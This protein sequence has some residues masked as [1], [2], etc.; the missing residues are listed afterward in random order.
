MY[1]PNKDGNIV[2]REQIGDLMIEA[3]AKG[4]ELRRGDGSAIN[5]SVEEAEVLGMD[6][7][8]CEYLRLYAATHQEGL[9]EAEKTSR[10]IVLA[11]FAKKRNLEGLRQLEADGFDNC[12]TLA[13]NAIYEDAITQGSNLDHK[14]VER[15]VNLGYKGIGERVEVNVCNL[16]KA[17]GENLT[18]CKLA[19]DEI[20]TD[21]ATI[22]SAILY[23]RSGDLVIEFSESCDILSVDKDG[24]T[25]INGYDV[26]KGTFKL[27]FDEMR[28][29]EVDLSKPFDKVFDEEYA[30]VKS[31][32]DAFAKDLIH[33]QRYYV[34]KIHGFYVDDVRL[35]MNIIGEQRDY[36]AL[37]QFEA[38]DVE[39][40]E[41]VLI[42][43]II[44]AA[45][46]EGINISR[47]LVAKYVAGDIVN[48]LAEI[49]VYSLAETFGDNLKN[50]IIK[51][52]VYTENSGEKD[53]CLFNKAGEMVIDCCEADISILNINGEGVT[54]LNT[55][56]DTI[57]LFRLSL[58]EA[59]ATRIDIGEYKK[60]LEYKKHFGKSSKQQNVER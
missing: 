38:D 2:D 27:S 4:I 14:D 46:A 21:D 26:S 29:L 35:L 6:V 50:C 40:C 54:L 47:E 37:Q 41:K 57:E 49:N 34:E 59:V 10:Q 51:H 22:E 32:I 16:Y 39:A 1:Y 15:Y 11:L 25:L 56:Y 53:V 42:D 8:D 45:E 33:S 30:R 44:K 55:N 13:I 5:L 18:F 31:E 52:D 43:A 20:G 3:S 58:E 28:A 17:F 48:G 9:S 19:P 36:I 23:N 60:Q 24:V 7:F 12:N